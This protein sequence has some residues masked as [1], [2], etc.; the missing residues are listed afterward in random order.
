LGKE[1]AMNS[2]LHPGEAADALAEIHK[3]QQQVIDR[4]IVPTWYWWAV[5]ALMVV[6]AVGVDIRTHL[7]LGIT[8]PVFVVGMLAATGAA[9][10]SQF[11]DARLRDE[12]LDGS[13]VVAILGFVALIVGCSLGIAFG[14]RAAGVSYPATIGCGVGGLVM[15][16][17][18]PVLSRQ[19]RRI[20][21]GNRTG[22]S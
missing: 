14:L 19:L 10:R 1:H 18:G 8:I 21:L 6:L 12:L 15:G 4:A 5:G 16:L 2:E 22:T 11:L 20:M 3:R 13:G 7:A 17:G 9:V